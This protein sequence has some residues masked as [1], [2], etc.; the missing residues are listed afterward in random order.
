M[1]THHLHDNSP[2]TR[3]FLYPQ[4]Q[5]E[6]A[7]YFH[8][9]SSCSSDSFHGLS[10]DDKFPEDKH[11]TSTPNETNKPIVQEAQVVKS[12]EDKRKTRELIAELVRAE[13]LAHTSPKSKASEDD[14]SN[15]KKLSPYEQQMMQL[16]RSMEAHAQLSPDEPFQFSKSCRNVGEMQYRMGHME[17]AQE[18]LLVGLQ[19]LIEDTPNGDKDA[20][21]LVK[22]QIMHLLGAVMARCGE[23]DEAHNWYGESLKLKSNMLNA[24]QTTSEISRLHYEV[25]KTLNGLAA[26]EVMATADWEKASSLF[27][28]AERSFLHDYQHFLGDENVHNVLGWDEVPKEMVDLMTPHLVQLV[29]NVRS[30]M[31]ELFRQQKRHSDAVEMFTLALDLAQM[32]VSRM[33]AEAIN[34]DVQANSSELGD[35]DCSPDEPSPEERRNTVVDLLIKLADCHAAS[36]SYDD[37]A[38]SYEQALASHVQFRKLS[39]KEC[40]RFTEK[41]AERLNTRLPAAT[42]STVNIPLDIVSATT[43]EAAIRNNLAHSLTRVGQPKLALE[44]YETSLQI[45]RHIGGDNHM[46]VGRTLLEMGALLGG[47]L[48]DMITS[49]N[50]FKEALHI[51]HCNRDEILEA[52]SHRDEN[53]RQSFY[54]VNADLELDDINECV[55]NAAKN[56]A[57]IQDSLLK[58]RGGVGKA[59]SS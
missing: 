53:S 4:P 32:D 9:S 24:T 33:S 45:K 56:I 3:S 46:E 43:M 13:I 40:N 11:P 31:G 55:Q 50:C 26:L 59:A 15:T 44:Q 29:I 48:N 51:F 30:N 8:S 2:N 12:E 37:A 23:F 42:F 21:Q 39:G 36:E 18:I 16:E 7:C 49:L 17:Q 57:L 14:T 25:G 47:P 54:D 1:S 58:D 6:N 52:N 38:A 41:L 22:A 20:I 28:D 34:A 19:T 27:H 10:L 35:P 5:Q